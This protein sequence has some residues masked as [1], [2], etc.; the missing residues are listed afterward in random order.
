MK[1]SI[2]TEKDYNLFY[3]GALYGK[4]DDPLKTAIRVAYRDLCRTVRGFSKNIRHDEIFSEATRIIYQEVS[5]LLTQDM[6]S[7]DVFDIWHKICCD[8][9]I[10]AFESQEFYYGQAQKWINMCLK[11]LSMLEHSLVEKQ[12]EYFHIPIDNYIVDITGIKLSVAWSRL[13]DYNEY[14]K[15]QKNFRKV[16]EGIPLDNEFKLWL[17]VAR[18]VE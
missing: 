10:K 5:T 4:I 13:D 1:K 18:Y 9:V 16:Y 3:K 17:K 7:Q 14:L 11:Y 6:Y 15:F 8:N 12:Y 2:L